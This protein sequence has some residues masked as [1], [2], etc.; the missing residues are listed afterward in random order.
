MQYGIYNFEPYGK[1]DK[2]KFKGI[3]NLNLRSHTELKIWD[4]HFTRAFNEKPLIK[5][6]YHNFYAA[7]NDSEADLFLCEEN[8]KIYIPCNHELME[9]AG[10][11]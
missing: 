3:A 5:Y 8:G 6:D 4:E 11:R 2:N 10:Y 9:F 7:M 1:L